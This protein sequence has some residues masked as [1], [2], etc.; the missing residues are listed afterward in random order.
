VPA[1]TKLAPSVY[2]EV[3]RWVTSGY[4][5]KAFKGRFAGFKKQES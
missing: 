2:R 3:E 1:S 5:P 4:L